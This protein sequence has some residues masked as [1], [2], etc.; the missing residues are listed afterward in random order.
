[1]ADGIGEAFAAADRLVDAE[2]ADAVVA[3]QEH[4]QRLEALQAR[5]SARF[6]A[7][8]S[9]ADDGARSGAAWLA[10][11]LRVPQSEARRRILAGRSCRSMPVVDEAWRAGRIGAAHVVLLARAEALD[12]RAFARDEE[13]LVGHATSLRFSAFQRAVAYWC[14]LAAP[15]AVE[16]AAD[17]QRALRA[18]HLSPSIDGMWFGKVTLDPVGGS[19]VGG[20]LARLEREMFEADWREATDRLGRTPCVDDLA[21]TPAQRRADALVEMA[22]RSGS[23]P[24][25]AQRPAPLFSVLVGLETFAGRVCELA[26]GAVVTPGSLVPWLTEAEV[27]RVVFDGASRVIDVGVRQRFFRGATRRAAQVR[28]RR[29]QHPTCDE[30]LDRCQVDHIEPAAA[31]G[32]TTLANA[33]LLCGF[34][35][36]LRA[37]RTGKT[38]P[39]DDDAE[40][41]PA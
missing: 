30:P 29:C 4:A 37:T 23:T 41:D 40:A 21:R 28:D 31:G 18:V 3:L 6:D 20:E 17:A 12:A 7:S 36:R 22:T 35:N 13:L 25:G 33:R 38:S 11:R 16:D 8:R 39:T 9:W 15:D 1:M 26:N 27:E 2:L 24:E 14:Q 19:I 34:H 10:W 5:V 32:L